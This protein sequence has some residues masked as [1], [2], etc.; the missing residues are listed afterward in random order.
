[1]PRDSRPLPRLHAV[2]DDALLGRPDFP[3]L[4][5]SVLTAGRERVALQLRGRGTSGARL[6][7]LAAAL[8]PAARAV[9]A[10]LLVNDRVDVARVVDLDGVHLASQ[11]LPPVVAR[12]LLPPERWVGL[13]VHDPVGARAAAEH[14][15]YLVV[16]T[17]FA[18]PSHPG[19]TGAGPEL[20]AR[21]RAAASLPLLA[22]GGIGP[23]RVPEVVAAGASG[24]AVLSGIWGAPDPGAAVTEYLRRLPEGAAAEAPRSRSG[25]VA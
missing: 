11:S 1:V 4:A 13:S 8:R 12:Q 22:I 23:E 20:V 24:V 5:R 19:R 16:G 2:T 21:V 25:G 3:E 6:Y 17:V 18:T 7:E 10:L 15:D 14:A 9:G